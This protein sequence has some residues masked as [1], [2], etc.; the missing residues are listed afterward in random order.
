MVNLSS[1]EKIS[2]SD[3]DFI[4][5]RTFL[6]ESFN[7]LKVTLSKYFTWIQFH[8]SHLWIVSRNIACNKS[9]LSKTH[10]SSLKKLQEV[11]S[12]SEPIL[13]SSQHAPF[14]FIWITFNYMLFN[15]SLNDFYFYYAFRRIFFCDIKKYYICTL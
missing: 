6:A 9:T 12:T 5:F 15:S 2:E 13:F 11:T 3:V 1:V 14:L 7:C 10:F 4:F 8:K